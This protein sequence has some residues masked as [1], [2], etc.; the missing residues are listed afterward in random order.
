MSWNLCL[1]QSNGRQM[2]DRTKTVLVWAFLAGFSFF[3]FVRI[4]AHLLCFLSFLKFIFQSVH[5]Y[6]SSLHY[7]VVVVVL[8]LC[9]FFFKLP[10]GQRVLM[11]RDYIATSRFGVCLTLPDSLC[12]RLHVDGIYLKYCLCELF[13]FLFQP[14]AGKKKP[15][16]TAHFWVLVYG[17][18]LWKC[19]NAATKICGYYNKNEM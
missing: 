16:T 13:F 1:S 14:H 19:L 12:M 9:P 11:P 18:T 6:V 8:R 17:V 3:P 10:I 4:N 7:T 5:T 15:K 2:A